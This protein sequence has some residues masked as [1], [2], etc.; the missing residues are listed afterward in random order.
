[1]ID[2]IFEALQEQNIIEIRTEIICIDSTSIKVH[3]DAAE[4]RKK[5]RPL[6]RGTHNKVSF[7]FRVCEI[8]N[9]FLAVFQKQTRCTRRKK[10]Y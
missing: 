6:K 2:C 5:H 3:T 4:A 10:T 8:C 1:M 9:N 7:D